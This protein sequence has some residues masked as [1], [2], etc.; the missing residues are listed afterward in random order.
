MKPKHIEDLLRWKKQSIIKAR[1]AKQQDVQDTTGDVTVRRMRSALQSMYQWAVK[2]EYATTN[3]VTLTDLG[4]DQGRPRGRVLD[5]QEI[6]DFWYGL[7]HTHMQEIT[8]LA[9]KLILVTGQRSGEVLSM[10]ERHIRNGIWT[11]PS[12]ERKQTKRDTKGDHAIPLGPLAEQIIDEARQA[13]TRQR[14]LRREKAQK[15][16]SRGV[17]MEL[18]EESDLVFPSMKET[19]KGSDTLGQAVH[20]P[21]HLSALG[22]QDHPTWGHWRPHDLRRTCRTSLPLCKVSREVAERVIGH[23]PNAQAI[24]HVYNQY[25]YKAA[26]REALRR[27]EEL[28]QR[29]L[30]WKGDMRNFGDLIEEE[31]FSAESALERVTV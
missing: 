16:K 27:W 17:A 5:W 7:Q 4:K 11:I 18:P 22:N 21:E 12:S 28:L 6:I 23:E 26:K 25:M 15:A 8:Q 2:H 10:R 30:S 13:A 24:E 31:A 19:K 9:L 29:A 14:A 20:N 3:P 1:L